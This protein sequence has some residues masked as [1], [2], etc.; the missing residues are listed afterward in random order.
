MHDKNASSCSSSGSCCGGAN[1]YLENGSTVRVGNERN[2]KKEEEPT[3][4]KKLH[5]LLY[6]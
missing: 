3:V 5:H 6:T 2:L 1:N 4:V